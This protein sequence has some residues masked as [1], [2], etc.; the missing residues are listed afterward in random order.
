M[1]DKP[2]TLKKVEEVLPLLA[3]EGVTLKVYFS[4]QDKR[5]K[6]YITIVRRPY[7]AL[8]VLKLLIRERLI[9]T[10]S[11]NYP[12]EYTITEEGRAHPSVSKLKDEERS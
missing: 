9:T 12:Y 3:R 8:S 7:V 10:N 5:E 4:S 11:R 1:A 6:A 2:E